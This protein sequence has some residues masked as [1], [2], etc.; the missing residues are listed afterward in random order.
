MRPAIKENG[1]KY[2]KLVLCYVDNVLAI[3]HDPTKTMDKASRS[4]TL[5]NEKAVDPET[6]LGASLAKTAT[7]DGVECWTM[8]SEKYCKAAVQNV[9]STLN[10]HVRRLP[11]KCRAPLKLGYRP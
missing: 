7:T 11:S 2:Y 8:S 9:K 3:S 4:F 1:F 10:A 5:K 6:Y